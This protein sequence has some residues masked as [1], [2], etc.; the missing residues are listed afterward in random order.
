MQ[1]HAYS[2]SAIMR[3][4]HEIAR[5]RR[6]DAARRAHDATMTVVAGRI[7]YAKSYAEIIAAMPIDMSTALKQAWAEVKQGAQ[8]STASM[9]PRNRA[10]VLHRPGRLAPL[11]RRLPRLWSALARVGRWLNSRFI[12]ARAA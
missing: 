1:I 8:H 10:L 3:R 5:Q 12:P 7:V 4:A 2:R 9:P 11:R 6:A